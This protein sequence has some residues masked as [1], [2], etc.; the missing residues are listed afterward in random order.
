MGGAF[1]ETADV[2]TASEDYARRFAGPVGAWFLELQARS[3]LELLSPLGRGARVLDVGGGHAQLTPA[4][5]DQ[6]YE[7]TVVGSAPACAQR[8]SALIA[9]GRCRFEV[10]NV[11]DLPY[12]DRSFDAALSF[13]LLPHVTA[14]QALLAGLCRVARR[15]VL[16]DY[17]SSRSINIL[18]GRLFA[19]KKR[20]EGNTRP[21]V[22]YRPGEIERAFLA[23]GFRVTASRAQF[24]WPMVLHRM[25]G[26]VGVSKALEA[27]GRAIGL[28]GVLGSPVIVRADR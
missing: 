2:E 1:A 23:N 26:R 22:Q 7:V 19:A 17:P 3:T 15:S 16:V 20:V 14:W 5:V 9:G 12:G 13:R 18:A 24:L 27:P 8:L 25:I 10:A 6:G 11:I 28:L 4:L 21:F